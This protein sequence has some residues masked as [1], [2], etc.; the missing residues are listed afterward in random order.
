MVP[1]MDK[2]I[3]LRHSILLSRAKAAVWISADTA[4]VAHITRGGGRPGVGLFLGPSA[5]YSGR[6]EHPWPA[7]Y[8]FTIAG[9][10]N[11]KPRVNQYM[12]ASSSIGLVLIHLIGFLMM[13]LFYFASEL[14]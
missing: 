2:R 4:H 7:Q 13:L 5:I 9:Q 14:L 3:I 1:E 8:S 12:H 10:T 6:E 11:K